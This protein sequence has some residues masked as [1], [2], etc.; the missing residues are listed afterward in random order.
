MNATDGTG[1]VSV[2]EATLRD[3]D[4]LAALF[5]AYRVFYER[6]SDI[7]SSKRFVEER[8]AKRTTNFFLAAR[9]NKAVGFVHLLPSFDTLA[10]KRTW[11][12]EDLFVELLQRRSGVGAS[13]LRCAER[14]AVSTEAA[15]ISLTTAHTNAAAQ[16]LY[17]ANGYQRDEVFLTYHRM[18]T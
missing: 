13:L 7:E 18:L 9:D 10:M 17:L 8:L 5:D 14:F 2:L 6:A 11:L 3:V 1:P 16:R 15:R 4:A 12:L